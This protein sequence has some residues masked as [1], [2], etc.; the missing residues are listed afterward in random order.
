MAFYLAIQ[1]CLKTRGKS[2]SW[3][4]RNSS[5]LRLSSRLLSLMLWSKRQI[6]VSSLKDLLEYYLVEGMQD[7][8]L[9]R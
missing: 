3:T 2:L 1:G 8:L 4:M 9:S 7:V 6:L 5:F